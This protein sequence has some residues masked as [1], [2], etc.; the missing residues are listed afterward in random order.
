MSECF[1]AADFR[2]ETCLAGVETAFDTKKMPL[3]ARRSYISLD[4]PQ[5]VHSWP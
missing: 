2:V 3:P 1:F 5:V 4:Q